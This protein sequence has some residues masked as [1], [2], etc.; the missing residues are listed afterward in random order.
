MFTKQVILSFAIVWLAGCSNAVNYHHS[1][2]NSIALEVRTTDPQQPLQGVIGIKTRT[3]VVA[4]G[5][6]GSSDK[7]AQTKGD[8]K[9]NGESTSVISDFNLQRKESIGFWA[10]GSTS[11]QSA[12]ITGDA[13]KAAPAGTVKALS[14]L[15]FEGAGDSAI[16]KKN[17][18]ANIYYFL[19]SNQATDE[20][21][22]KYIV[23]LDKL[24]ELLPKNYVNNTYYAMSVSGKV[25]EKRDTSNYAPLSKA[26]LEV[27]NYE[28][29]LILD[30]IISLEKMEAD[31]S[32][33]YKAS[34]ADSATDITAADLIMLQGELKRL[35]E[36]RRAFFDMIA[37]HSVID[38]AAAYMTSYL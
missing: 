10:F 27:L 3:I 12:F 1:E 35:K 26:F 37:N 31:R 8:G 34:A 18:L 13:A 29:D 14:G 21:A 4:P 32:I 25:L 20:K 24:L 2:R 7:E 16:F 38:Q 9:D 5:L 36:E 11:I 6:K 15:G 19:D 28:D 22:K 23:Q 30:S 17:V 33:K